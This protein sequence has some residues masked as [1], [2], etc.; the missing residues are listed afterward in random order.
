MYSRTGRSKKPSFGSTTDDPL[1][2]AGTGGKD[3]PKG[4][5]RPGGGQVP[6]I[7][8]HRDADWDDR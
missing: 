3:D 6:A 7:S 5:A 2:T 1:A 8:D 4:K